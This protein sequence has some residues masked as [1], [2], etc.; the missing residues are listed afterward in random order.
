VPTIQ[1]REKTGLCLSQL[2]KKLLSGGTKMMFTKKCEMPINQHPLVF[3]RENEKLGV[4][5]N[6]RQNKISPKLEEKKQVR[7]SKRWLQMC[8]MWIRKK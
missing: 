1:A 7:T 8:Q 6:S 5:E 3:L 2:K 4:D